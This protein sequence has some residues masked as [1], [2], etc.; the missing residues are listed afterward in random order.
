VAAIPVLAPFDGGGKV[1][2]GISEVFLSDVPE[3]EAAN[4]G[5]VDQADAPFKLVKR[6]CGR[7]VGSSAVACAHGSDLKAQVRGKGVH[8]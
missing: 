7:G 3:A 1:G 6:R 4:P 2:E 8:E 5:R